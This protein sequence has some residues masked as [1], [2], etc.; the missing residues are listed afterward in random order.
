MVGGG[1]WWVVGIVVVVVVV[2]YGGTLSGKACTKSPQTT[3]KAGRGESLFRHD[4]AR[5]QR[6]TYMKATGLEL[7]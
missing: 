7:G 1:C 2:V 3:A 4:T 5:S 6:D